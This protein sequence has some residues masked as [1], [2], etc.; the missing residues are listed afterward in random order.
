[1]CCGT[2]VIANGCDFA[3]WNC[4]DFDL[5]PEVIHAALGTITSHGENL[6]QKCLFAA[7]NFSLSNYNK[8][9]EKIYANL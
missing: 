4:S 5:L 1:L 6:K 9:M 2:P 3:S 7:R 8:Q